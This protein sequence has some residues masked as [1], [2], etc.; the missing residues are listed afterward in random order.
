MPQ[1]C[2]RDFYFFWP[3]NGVDTQQRKVLVG[4]CK[5]PLD[6]EQVGSIAEALLAAVTPQLLLVLAA[7]PVRSL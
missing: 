5:C 4:L 2:G 7:L 6:A 1:L 3:K